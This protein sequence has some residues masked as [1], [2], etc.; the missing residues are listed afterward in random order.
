MLQ[1]S[2]VN[3]LQLEITTTISSNLLHNNIILDNMF[4]INRAVTSPI[5]QVSTN[6][7]QDKK[8][9]NRSPSLSHSLNTLADSHKEVNQLNHSWESLVM[10]GISTL[11]I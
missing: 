2:T 3:Q 10:V 8:V 7:K 6:R 4:L 1:L 11:T 5:S 9:I